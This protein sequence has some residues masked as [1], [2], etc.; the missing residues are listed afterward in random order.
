MA[1]AIK[2]LYDGR[3]VMVLG[4]TTT[5]ETED[6]NLY[7]LRNSPSVDRHRDELRPAFNAEPIFS[8][9]YWN[10]QCDVMDG[11]QLPQLLCYQLTLWNQRADT[12]ILSI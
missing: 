8:D 3:C 12:R 11:F 7:T 9:S 6:D 10:L 1:I 5:Q 4:A 2:R